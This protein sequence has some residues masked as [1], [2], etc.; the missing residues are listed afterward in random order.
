MII[1]GN[2][3]PIKIAPMLADIPYMDPMGIGF[4]HV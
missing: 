4:N 2:M 3:D 1:Y